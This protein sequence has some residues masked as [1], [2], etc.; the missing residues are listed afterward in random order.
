M[1]TALINRVF[2]RDG[3]EAALATARAAQAPLGIIRSLEDGTFTPD[4]KPTKKV[5]AEVPLGSKGDVT[6][7]AVKVDGKI[8]RIVKTIRGESG[9][10]VSA[11]PLDTVIIAEAM[12]IIL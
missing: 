3:A 10:T 2:N 4:F 9:D 1:S 7:H 12:K 6:L 8:V 11:E 5:T